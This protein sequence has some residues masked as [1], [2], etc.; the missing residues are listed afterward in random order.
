MTYTQ[1]CDKHEGQYRVSNHLIFKNFLKEFVSISGIDM[2]ELV[3][4]YQLA[5]DNYTDLFWILHSYLFNHLPDLIPSFYELLEKYH[6]KLG[7]DYISMLRLAGNNTEYELKDVVKQF[8]TRAPY[9]EDVSDCKG[10]ITIHSGQLGNITFYSTAKYFQN[11][12]LIRY[13]LENFPTENE[14]HNISWKLTK[15]LPGSILITSLIPMPFEGT[16]YHTTV[17]NQDG[18]IVDAANG[19]VLEEECYHQMFQDE[20]IVET[21]ASDLERRL[22]ETSLM[23]SRSYPSALV[24]ALHEQKKKL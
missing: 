2:K 17:R 1:I 9:I 11:D 21:K 16:C 5:E 20:V 22:C 10:K 6:Y 19:V 7:T 23:E 15:V 4:S 14:C 12:Y 8:L 18:M 24:L 13:L 3:V